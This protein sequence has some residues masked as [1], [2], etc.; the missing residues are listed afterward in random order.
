MHRKYYK[1]LAETL[2]KMDITGGQLDLF[3]KEIGKVESNFDGRKFY[4]YTLKMA[5]NN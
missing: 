1:L 3:I 2:A 4:D 5:S